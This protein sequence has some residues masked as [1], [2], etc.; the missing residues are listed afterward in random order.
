MKILLAAIN[1]RYN[2][3]NLAVRSLSLYAQAR[4]VSP[5]AITF[6]EWTINQSEGEILRGIASHQPDMVLFS[7]YIWNGAM[8]RKLLQDIKKVL[9]DITVGAGGPE[10]GFYP[11]GYLKDFPD[12]DFVMTGEGEETVRELAEGKDFHQVQGIFYRHECD[13]GFC[14]FTG[15][16]PLLCNLD[17]LPFPYPE[18]TDP[19]NRIYYYESARGCPFSCAYCMSSLDKRVRFLSL[20]RVYKDLQTFIDAGV[21]LVKFVDRTYNLNE[22]RYIAIWQYILDHHADNGHKT[23]FH[24]EIEAEYL[25][26]RALEFLQQVPKG[27]MQFEIGVQSSHAETL[28]AVG[29]SPETAKLAE[30]ISR[31]PRTIHTHLDLIAGLPYEDLQVFGH[32]Y[33]FVMS[34]RPD[35]LQLGFLKV[36]HGTTM[37]TYAKENGWQWM[38]EPPYETFSTPYLSYD[39]MNFLKD[40]EVITDAYWNSGLFRHTMEYLGRTKGFWQFIT[41]TARLARSD[42]SLDDARRPSFWFDWLA[43][44]TELADNPVILLNLLKYDYLLQGKTSSFP[45]WYEHRYDKDAHREALEKA[46]ITGPARVLYGSTELES[47]DINPES[48]MH[49]KDTLPASISSTFLFIWKKPGYTDENKTLEITLNERRKS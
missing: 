47:F 2:H 46:G 42:G 4:G 18:I 49:A 23:M 27:V 9:P 5:D 29:R 38:A 40:V 34:L 17:E 32:S 20:E 43:S 6:G 12:L 37:E 22:D 8:V 16:R 24:F 7:T 45:A 41:E 21:R 1:A 26:D 25:S 36:L 28:K 10:A 15:D 35:A 33:D 39:D 13:M 48:F 14:E 31:I 11:E 3:T 30:N 19:D 44:H